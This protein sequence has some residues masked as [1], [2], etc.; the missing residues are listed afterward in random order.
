MITATLQRAWAD[1]SGFLVVMAIM[2]LAY[3]I[4]V[5]SFPQLT[6]TGCS[7]HPSGVPANKE[8]ICIIFSLIWCMAGSCTHIGLCWMLLRPWSACSLAFSTM[9]RPVFR[10]LWFWLIDRKKNN[11]CC[12][13]C[14][15]L[16]Y[17]L[18]TWLQSSTWCIP[19]WLLH[20]VYDLRGAQPLHLCHFGG[21]QSRANT[22][23]GKSPMLPLYEKIYKNILL[24]II[25]NPL[26]KSPFFCTAIRGGGNCGPDADETWQSV[27]SQM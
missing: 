20:C 3:S 21:V 4:A 9:K 16:C 14:L 27:W 12:L 17:L 25:L 23:Q 18:G 13:F 26:S 6:S 19:H 24:N 1:I 5:S 22:S 10:L 2:F 15:F 7:I 8:I 11:S